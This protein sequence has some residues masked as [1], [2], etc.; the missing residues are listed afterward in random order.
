[1][2][3]KLKASKK[4]KMLEELQAAIEDRLGDTASKVVFSI[5]DDNVLSVEKGNRVKPTVLVMFDASLRMTVG[6][7]RLHSADEATEASM[8]DERTGYWYDMWPDRGFQS[9]DWLEEAAEA[10]V[11]TIK[12]KLA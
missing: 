8:R 4:R 6:V 7:A 11:A 1:M 9:K 3:K 12:E 10:M 2:S 5:S